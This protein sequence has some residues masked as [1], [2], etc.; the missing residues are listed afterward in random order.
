MIFI[1]NQNNKDFPLLCYIL[2]SS[3]D[4]EP[5]FERGLPNNKAQ[6]FLLSLLC[7]LND[8]ASWE[9]PALPRHVQYTSCIF[10]APSPIQ[11]L[12]QNCSN[13][14]SEVLA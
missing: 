4:V 2:R 1:I 3:L 11:N 6:L 7:Y 9:A 5:G 14:N 8:A 10:S 12:L 13:N